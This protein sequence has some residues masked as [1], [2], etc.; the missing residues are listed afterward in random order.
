[1][2]KRGRL[3]TKKGYSQQQVADLLHIPQPTYHKW[4][5]DT[6]KPGIVNPLLNCVQFLK[7]KLMICWKMAASL[8]PTI[9]LN[10][11]LPM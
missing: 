9:L 5:T 2:R 6:A 8:F 4:E 7:W 11:V 1:M 3:R 10:P